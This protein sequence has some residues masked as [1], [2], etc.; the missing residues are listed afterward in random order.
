M[1]RWIFRNIALSILLWA[2]FGFVIVATIE[3]LVFGRVEPADYLASALGGGIG[4]TVAKPLVPV[5]ATDS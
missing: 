5:R 4:L 1:S 3:W 2:T